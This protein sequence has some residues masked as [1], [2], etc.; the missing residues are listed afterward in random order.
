MRTIALLTDFGNDCYIGIV[1]GVILSINQVNIVD[2]IHKI[3]PQNIIE[4]SFILYN[5]YRYFPK[6][7]IFLV[8]VDPTVGSKRNPI[9]IKT[10]DY[11]FIGPDNGILSLSA[12]ENGIKKI[13]LLENKK[14]FLNK[15]SNTFHARDIFAPVAAYVSKGENISNFGK[16][17]KDIEELEFNKPKIEKNNL[18]G[19]ILYKD[20]FGNLITN[21]R[22]KDLLNF[23]NNKKFIAY[24]NNKKIT[25]IYDYYSQAKENEL[26]FIEN[27]FQLLEISVK[28]KSAAEYLN[29]KNRTKK[30]FIQVL[31]L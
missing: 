7:T 18:I 10:K 19:E 16:E 27:S 1:K 24:I 30:I 26:F 2:I 5:S 31:N 4:G 11:Y 21:I 8:V 25:K 13:I 29:I 22:K 15:I 14:Y 12:K 20:S 28:N 3:T 6:N 17:I 23:I 9:L